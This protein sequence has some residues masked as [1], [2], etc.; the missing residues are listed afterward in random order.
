MILHGGGFAGS[1]VAQEWGDLPLIELQVQMVYSQ[2]PSL[3]VDFHQI[4]DA[5]A[6]DHITGLWFNAI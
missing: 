1:I 6:Q 2:F 3:L 5:H 4:S